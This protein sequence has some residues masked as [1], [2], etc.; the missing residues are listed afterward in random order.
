MGTQTG[1]Y[2]HIQ[3]MILNRRG[4]LWGI[5]HAH[6]KHINMLYKQRILWLIV[7]ILTIREKMGELPT[8]KIRGYTN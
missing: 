3:T 7:H 1:T 2:A 6:S 5:S 8:D 4:Q